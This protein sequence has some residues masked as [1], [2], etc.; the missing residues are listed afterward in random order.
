MLCQFIEE[1]ATNE[2]PKM[3]YQHTLSQSGGYIRPTWFLL[4]NQFTAEVFSNRLLLK[5]IRKS[6][7]ELEI[8]LTGGQTTTNLQGDLPGYGTE[9][10]HLGGIANTLSLSKV[11]EKHHMSYDSTGENKFLVYLTRG[12]VRSFSKCKRGLFYSD[13]AAGKGAVLLNTIDHNKSKYS[14]RDYTRDLLACKLQYRIDLPSHRHLVKIAEDKF[15]IINCPLNIDDDRGA[16][17]I[18]ENNLVCLKGKT[19]R[20]KMPHIRGGFCPSQ[21]PSY[22]DTRK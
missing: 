4:D 16:E 17:D 15:N 22:K 12:E 2:D 5:N 9:W 6:D 19:P 11:V 10:F 14:K 13:M 8:L 20:Q 1:T 3:E 21:P 18:W 7:R